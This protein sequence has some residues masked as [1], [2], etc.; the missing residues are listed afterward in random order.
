VR[1]L[2]GKPST[3]HEKTP[4]RVQSMR[5]FSS[6]GHIPGGWDFPNL[7]YGAP[8]VFPPGLTPR[9]SGLAGSRTGRR[10]SRLRP[11]TWSTVLPPFSHAES[12][13]R[14]QIGRLPRRTTPVETLFFLTRR[15]E[16]WSGLGVVLCGSAGILIARGLQPHG[17]TVGA[18]YSKLSTGLQVTRRTP[19]ETARRLVNPAGG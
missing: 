1:P 16:D 12:T 4:Q 14:I 11:P 19:N 6:C 18:P 5:V 2:A 13:Q 7:E 9:G 3:I 10:R 17:K 8:T 15:T